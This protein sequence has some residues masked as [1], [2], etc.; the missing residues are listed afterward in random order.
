MNTDFYYEI[1][2]SHTICEDYAIAG[3]FA[4]DISFAIVCDGCSASPHVDVGARIIA[5]SAQKGLKCIGKAFKYVKSSNLFLPIIR[6]A[7]RAIKELE[8][9]PYC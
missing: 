7:D 3:K 8:I 4:S 1:G 9:E 6:N 2:H 5:H